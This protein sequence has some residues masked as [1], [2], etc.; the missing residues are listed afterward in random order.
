MNS[1]RESEGAASGLALTAVAIVVMALGSLV[2][3]S[4]KDKHRVEEIVQKWEKR[5]SELRLNSGK[6]RDNQS[7]ISQATSTKSKN[8]AT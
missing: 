2:Y 5:R 6:T 1:N 7:A 3:E 4:L 8:E